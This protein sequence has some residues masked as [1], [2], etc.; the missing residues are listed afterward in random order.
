MKRDRRE[1]MEGGGRS[2]PKK[3]LAWPAG[4][5]TGLLEKKRKDENGGDWALMGGPLVCVF[6]NEK[7]YAIRRLFAKPIFTL[8]ASFYEAMHILSYSY[9]VRSFLHPNST[10]NLVLK[11]PLRVL[12]RMEDVHH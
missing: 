12:E 11:G 10:Q 1:M 9:S 6:F 8:H 3:K 2:E 4:R 5:K 7:T